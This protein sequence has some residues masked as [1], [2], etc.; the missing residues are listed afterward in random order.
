VIGVASY[1][2]EMERYLVM[3]R[4]EKLEN[5]Y[6]LRRF[7]FWLILLTTSSAIPGTSSG[8]CTGKTALSPAAMLF[9][10]YASTRE[11]TPTT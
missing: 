8:L 4:I 7:I 10:S 1:S 9:I 2:L 5:M 6:Y 3:G 11:P